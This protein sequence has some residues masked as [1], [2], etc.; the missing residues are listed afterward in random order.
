MVISQL[1]NVIFKVQYIIKMLGMSS[2]H[3]IVLCG[4]MLLL[5]QKIM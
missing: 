1:W 4:D 2:I 3:L 5:E